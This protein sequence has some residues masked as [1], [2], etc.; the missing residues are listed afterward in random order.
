MLKPFSSRYN[1]P[2]SFLKPTGNLLVLLEEEYGDP[3]R[4]TL[5]SISITKVCGH[6]SESH[7]PPV[8]Q[9]QSGVNYNKD[10]TGRPK[11]LLHCPSRRNI[12]R[13]VFA[14]FGTPSGDCEN[15]AT[16]NCH[17]SSSRAI[18][19]KACLGKK[20]CSIGLSD[21]HFGGEPCPGIPKTLLI[22]AH[23]T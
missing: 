9:S 7:F 14:S 12:S 22:D 18:V 21:Q 8:A 6:V 20:K 15:Y 5:D 19:E 2:R 4:I 17:L 3:L 23:C 16:G 11:V 13:I 1:V 10:L